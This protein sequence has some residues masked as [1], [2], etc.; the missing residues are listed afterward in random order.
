MIEASRDG[1]STRL[2]NRSRTKRR[3]VNPLPNDRSLSPVFVFKI[4]SYLSFRLQAFTSYLIFTK[5]YAQKLIYII[6]RGLFPTHGIIVVFFFVTA[7]LYDTLLWGFNRSGYMPGSNLLRGSDVVE[8][9]LER[10][11]YV[12]QMIGGP[13]EVNL[14]S[15]AEAIGSE[16]FETGF[17]LTLTDKFD[18]ALERLG[19]RS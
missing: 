13:G 9:L 16:L 12:V 8:N 4:L 19:N 3:Q 14:T 1:Q 7:S 11:K 5:N 15:A 18:R 6:S 17:S 10:P 2:R